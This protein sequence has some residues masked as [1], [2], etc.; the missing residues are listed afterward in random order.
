LT[1]LAALNFPPIGELV[2]W[3][4]FLLPGFNK[5]V[6]IVLIACLGTLAL[7]MAAGRRSELVPSGVQNVTEAIVDFISD[8]IIMQTMG[9]DGMVFLPYLTTLFCFIFICNIFEVIPIIQFPATARMAFPLFLALITWVM[10]HWMGVKKQGFGGYIKSTLVPPGVPKALLPL[11]SLIEGLQAILVKPFSLAVRL[12]ANELAGHLLLVTFAVLTD[13]LLF[14]NSIV[15]FKPIAVLPA[16]MDVAL[17]G[18]EVLVAVLQAFI[19]TILTAV[20][21]GGAMHPEH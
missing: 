4:H 12:F 2:D 20:Y 14:H 18:F 6:L 3:K 8:G 1:V 13:T 15:F 7:F 21:L 19:F 17:T 9:P 11:V 5:P 10:Y 16:A